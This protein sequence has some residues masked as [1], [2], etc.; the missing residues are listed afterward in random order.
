MQADAWPRAEETEIST[1]LWALSHWNDFMFVNRFSCYIRVYVLSVGVE[2][3]TVEV[4][5]KHLSDQEERRVFD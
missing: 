3:V 1:I 4:C 2:S 5:S